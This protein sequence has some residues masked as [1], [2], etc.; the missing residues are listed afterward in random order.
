[1]SAKVGTAQGSEWE[2]AAKAAAAAAA[3]A[4]TTTTA[5][6]CALLSSTYDLLFWP[7]FPTPSLQNLLLLLRS[8]ILVQ[9][10]TERGKDGSAQLLWK[11]SSLLSRRP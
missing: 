3:A 6:Y 8:V 2:M 4:T 11:I 7:R 1:M 9:V 5:I 10:A